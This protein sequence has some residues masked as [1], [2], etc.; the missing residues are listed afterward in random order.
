MREAI[1]RAPTLQRILFAQI[2][3]QAIDDIYC[4]PS[5]R[6]NDIGHW[7]IGPYN[8]V[9][10]LNFYGNDFLTPGLL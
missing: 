7:A 6:L 2:S 10:L 1:K 4:T 5:E 8:P 3:S 9:D